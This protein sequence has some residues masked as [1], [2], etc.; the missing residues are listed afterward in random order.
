MSIL[1][2]TGENIENTHHSLINQD[3]PNKMTSLL[4]KKSVDGSMRLPSLLPPESLDSLCSL[5]V[6]SSGGRVVQL[7][8]SST[9]P[10]AYN[11][12]WGRSLGCW[13]MWAAGRWSFPMGMVTMK[14]LPWLS[15]DSLS[16]T[17]VTVIDPPCNLTNS[18][19]MSRAFDR[20]DQRGVYLCKWKPDSRSFMTSTC[21]LWQK[22][23]EIV[24]QCLALLT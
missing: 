2:S 7:L 13:I 14:Q 23:L 1:S 10:R 18:Y 17:E 8:A 22:S 9:I 24:K 3:W 19:Y 12:C 21:I 15:G 16:V 20:R 6:L 5:G 4:T 11:R